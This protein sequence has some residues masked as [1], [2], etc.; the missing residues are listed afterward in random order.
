M[1]ERFTAACKLEAKS[2]TADCTKI[3]SLKKLNFSMNK[4]A[5]TAHKPNTNVFKKGPAL[6]RSS[7]NPAQ[8]PTPTPRIHPLCRAVKTTN[9]SKRSG[10]M[11]PMAIIFTSVAWHIAI[12]DTIT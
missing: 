1:P 8:I 11:L 4:P 6:N 2:I 5:K 12:M 7:K 3:F 9:P 10:F